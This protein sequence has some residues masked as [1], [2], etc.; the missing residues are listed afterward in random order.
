VGTLYDR[1]FRTWQ[2]RS[3]E[4]VFIWNCLV[5]LYS[6]QK[7]NA[8]LANPPPVNLLP[9]FVFG[10]CWVSH[11]GV[12]ETRLALER[13]H[14]ALVTEHR[15]WNY[16]LWSMYFL[17]RTFERL[18]MYPLLEDSDGEPVRWYHVDNPTE[19]RTN[20]EQQYRSSSCGMPNSVWDV[21]RDVSSKYGVSLIWDSRFFDQVCTLQ[22]MG[23]LDF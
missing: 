22:R 1:I 14:Q 17:F 4:Y 23:R 11:Q 12:A 8:Y 9:S 16:G 13:L 10:R 2:F 19:V 15:D 18:I 7:I 21:Q 3:K 6:Y 5:A 20:I